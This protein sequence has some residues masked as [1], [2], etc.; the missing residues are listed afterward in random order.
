MN[1]NKRRGQS[2]FSGK[3]K[4]E[5]HDAKE[6]EQ[7]LARNLQLQAPARK[8]PAYVYDDFMNKTRNVNQLLNEFCQHRRKTINFEEVP[9]NESFKNYA[10][11]AVVDARKY[12]PGA[13]WTKQVAKEQASKNALRVLLRDYYK[14]LGENAK[15]DRIDNMDEQDEKI[16][17]CVDHPTRYKPQPKIAE[18]TIDYNLLTLT[19]IEKDDANSVAEQIAFTCHDLEITKYNSQ[20]AAF[21]LVYRGR[22]AGRE[23]KVVSIGTGQNKCYIMNGQI[24]HKPEQMPNKPGRVLNDTDALVLARRGLVRYLLHEAEEFYSCQRNTKMDGMEVIFKMDPESPKLILMD[25]IDIV[26]YLS[27]NAPHFILYQGRNFRVQDLPQNIRLG[28]S[29]KK[30]EELPEGQVTMRSADKLAKWCVTGVQGAIGSRIME[31]IYCSG[32]V[33]GPGEGHPDFQMSQFL[34]RVISK[35]LLQQSA[36]LPGSFIALM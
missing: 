15:V 1:Q 19:R 31:P 20:F 2:R 4:I 33:F 29:V 13:G 9:S 26:L 22:F 30:L 18:S 24:V 11:A 7:H 23:P 35:D 34:E 8:L 6:A 21:V 27:G 36:H 17:R 12:P 32:I 16:S 10:M 5:N 25:D 28:R 3:K 14:Q